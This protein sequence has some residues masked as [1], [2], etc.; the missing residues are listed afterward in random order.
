MARAS[1]L[2]SIR[3]ASG[4]RRQKPKT[5]AIGNLRIMSSDSERAKP[6]DQDLPGDQGLIQLSQTEIFAARH[7]ASNHAIPILG[8]DGSV[9]TGTAFRFGSRT[10]I[11]SAAH[12][13]FLNTDHKVVPIPGRNPLRLRGQ[14]A[15]FEEEKGVDPD[16]AVLLLLPEEASVLAASY[17]LLGIDDLPP[18]SQDYLNVFVIAGFPAERMASQSAPSPTVFFSERYAG[19]TDYF[20]KRVDP[21]THLILACSEE[22]LRV[23]EDGP[24]EI[25]QAPA[26]HGMSGASVWQLTEQLS[27]R[28]RPG[29]WD[30]AQGMKVVAVQTSVGGKR[31]WIRST[32]WSHVAGLVIELAPELEGPIRDRLCL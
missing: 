13:E 10:V 2:S 29:I 12:V 6:I 26:P 15:V 1:G 7:R 32:T 27:S 14:V 23:S 21:E 19:S 3:L 17:P 31:T 30:P 28:E 16:V 25:A 11:V 9:A 20:A 24:S 5:V 18:D 22:S 4:L 8:S